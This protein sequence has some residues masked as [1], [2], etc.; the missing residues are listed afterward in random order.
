MALQLLIVDANVLIDFCKTQPSIL[1]LVTRHLGAV[2][3][4]SPVLDEVDELD[5]ERAEALGIVV[6]TPELAM[7]RDAALAASRSP[8]SFADW[9]C[10][11]M[12]KERSWVCVTNDK[13][14]RAECERREIAALWGLQLLHQ[15]V[16]CDAMSASEALEAADAICNINRRISTAAL[17]AFGTKLSALK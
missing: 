7:A 1:G 2:H 17:A 10:L 12:A 8:L 15:L 4:A 16:Q 9:L 3:V 14:L 11:L 6:E 13:R 5:V